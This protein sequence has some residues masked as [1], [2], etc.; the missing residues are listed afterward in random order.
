MAS[1]ELDEQG[2]IR[3][4]VEKPRNPPSNLAL[5][6]IYMFDHNIFQAVNSIKPSWRGELELPTPSNG[7]SKRLCRSPVHSSWAVDRH[8]QTDRHAGSQQPRAGRNCAQES[9]ATWIATVRSTTGSPS[10]GA[11]RSSTAYVRGPADFR[12]D[13]RLINGY[14]RTLYE[15]LS[16]YDR[17]EQRN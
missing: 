8:G 17:R 12:E 15:H 1:A 9:T 7:W 6:G 5:V 4:L 14:N 2:R 16:R 3:R 13:A 11:R 10:N